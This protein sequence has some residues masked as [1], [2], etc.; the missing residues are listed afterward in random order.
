MKSTSANVAVNAMFVKSAVS[1][2]SNSLQLKAATS[3]DSTL[4]KL[5]YRESKAIKAS[6]LSTADKRIVN[7]ALKA[8]YSSASTKDASSANAANSVVIKNSNGDG[9]MRTV[10][11]RISSD[12]LTAL[13]SGST[14]NSQ[15]GTTATSLEGLKAYWGG[16]VRKDLADATDNFSTYFVTAFGAAMSADTAL[17]CKALTGYTTSGGTPV[18]C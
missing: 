13:R 9:G 18:G 11:F 3:T 16:V 1:Y 10:S 7:A 5:Y 2:T 17:G 4:K 14:T 8:A 15:G 12:Q 6:R